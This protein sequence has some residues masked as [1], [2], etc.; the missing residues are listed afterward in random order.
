M[1]LAH[2]L[3]CLALAAPLVVATL[4]VAGIGG[5]ERLG[6]TF[7]HAAPPANLAEAASTGRADDVVRR[8][9]AGED[10]AQ[11]YPLRPEAISSVVLHATTMEAAMWSRQLRMIQLLDREGAIGAQED[12]RFLVC[13]ASDLDVPDIVEFLAPGGAPACTRSEAYDR[14]LARTPRPADD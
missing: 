10:A 2:R 7:L 1:P 9:R 5:A 8:L 4:C 11:V 3:L 12:R 14:V 6:G 13:L